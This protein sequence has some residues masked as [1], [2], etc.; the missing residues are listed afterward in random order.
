MCFPSMTLRTCIL[1]TLGLIARGQSAADA[2]NRAP[3][4]VE[5]NL[6]GRVTAFYELHKEGKFRQA[7][8]YVCADSKDIY[9]DKDKR[10]W[11]SV[12]IIRINYENEFKAAKIVM[13][14]GT[15]IR[16][17]AGTIPAKYPLTDFWQIEDGQWCNH[18]P[19]PSKAETITPFGIMRQTESA[20]GQEPPRPNISAEMERV[21]VSKRELKLRAFETSSDELE[22]QNG[23]SGSIYLEVESVSVPGFKWSLPK[24]TLNKDEKVVLKV[25][26]EPAPGRS[27]VEF[28]LRVQMEPI[29]VVAP[30]RVFFDFSQDPKR[31]PLPPFPKP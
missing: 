8:L 24:K 25:T 29:S 10:R 22:I 20:K 31:Q 3:A 6:R 21:K 14:L 15:E 27:P 16:S 13:A 2:L 26:Y 18:I 9:Y 11:S 12:E 28:V 30:I 19:P 7:E 4:G 5:E 23:L 1:I 17:R